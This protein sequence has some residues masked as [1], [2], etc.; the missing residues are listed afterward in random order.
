VRESECADGSTEG[1]T[2]VGHCKQDDCD[3]YVGRG[4]GG[5]HMLEAEMGERGWLG[6]PYTLENHSRDESIAKFREAFE[7][8]VE[9]DAEFRR[10]V[11]RLSGKTLGCWCQ[12]EADDG[13]ACHGEVIAEYADRLAE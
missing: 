3:V 1:E 7:I 8:A 2:K 4:R 5:K 10:E 12:R 11:A 6:N 9:N 13:P